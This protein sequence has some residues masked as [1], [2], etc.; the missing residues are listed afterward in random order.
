MKNSS[1][2]QRRTARPR[3]RELP[4]QATAD[5]VRLD[6]D[7]PIPTYE[8]DRVLRG[9]SFKKW[10]VDD[11]FIRDCRNAVNLGAFVALVSA[12]EDMKTPAA[13]LK[14]R[15]LFDDLVNIC[16]AID[17]VEKFNSDA[18]RNVLK[19]RGNPSARSKEA[20]RAVRS[21]QRALSKTRTNIQDFLKQYSILK[22]GNNRDTFVSTYIWIAGRK[23][24]AEEDFSVRAAPFAKIL[25][26][27]WRDLGMPLVDH[28]GRPRRSVE[29]WLYDRIRHFVLPFD[30]GF[31]IPE[32]LTH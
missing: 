19:T 23:L 29:R 15:M 10:N 8:I 31:T 5:L 6:V 21:I 27:G 22:A 18:A 26:A 1:K 28:R 7:A 3:A 24:G 17:R 9:P 2:S 14:T 16:N 25:A 32:H 4:I 11:D 13:R 12:K 30:E 20:I